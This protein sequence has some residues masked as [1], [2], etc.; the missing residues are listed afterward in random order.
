MGVKLGLSRTG[1]TQINCGYC[2]SQCSPCS[3]VEAY[4]HFR[5]ACCIHRRGNFST[6]LFGFISRKTV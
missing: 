3:V 5:G 2:L 4:R 6:K 1:R